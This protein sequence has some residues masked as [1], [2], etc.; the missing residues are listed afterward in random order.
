M[1]K[2]LHSFSR[3]ISQS[4]KCIY[5]F[6]LSLT[7]HKSEFTATFTVFLILSHWHVINNNNNNNNNNN[8][9]CKSLS[10]CIEILSFGPFGGTNSL[11]FLLSTTRSNY[12]LYLLCNCNEYST[13]RIMLKSLFLT[14]TPI[15]VLHILRISAQIG[16]CA[17]E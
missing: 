13:S 8:K 9:Y 11:P 7:E 10:S 1:R 2:R 6:W 4:I 3:L 5:R 14:W 12:K 16:I 17:F 15:H